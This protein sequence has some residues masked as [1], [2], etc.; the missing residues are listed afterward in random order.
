ME[1]IPSI[2]VVVS[3]YNGALYIAEQLDSV[4]AQDYPNVH[5]VVRDDGSSDGTLSI[6][7]SYAARGD[8]ELVEGENVGVVS[9]FLG[10]VSH[11]AEAYDYVAQ[12]GRAHV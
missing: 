8:I 4:L 2:A 10:L 9:S 5:I 7:R 12:I 6:L 3:T 1:T 11:V